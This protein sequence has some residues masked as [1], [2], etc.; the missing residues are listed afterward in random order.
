MSDNIEH[1]DFTPSEPEDDKPETDPAKLAALDQEQ[2]AFRDAAAD[3]ARQ[4]GFVHDCKC[5]ED[6]ENG[7]TVEV[8]RCFVNLTNQA[9]ATLSYCNMENKQLR[10]YLTQLM[11]MN[12]DL[13]TMLKERG[14]ESDLQEYFQEEIDEEGETAEIIELEEAAQGD[15]GVESTPERDDDDDSEL[16]IS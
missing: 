16:S 14:F 13:A 5:A 1:L 2:Q 12:N 9:M 7:N 4:Y 6:Y 3:F 11:E 10:L 8:A 15:D